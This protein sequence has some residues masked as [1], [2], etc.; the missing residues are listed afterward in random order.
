MSGFLLGQTDTVAYCHSV[1]QVIFG[2]LIGHNMLIWLDDIPGFADTEDKLLD[3]LEQVLFLCEQYGLKLNP[4][5]CD[6][7]TT[8]VTW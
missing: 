3:T 5:K 2:E 1:G 7:F 4:S 8:E 6:F